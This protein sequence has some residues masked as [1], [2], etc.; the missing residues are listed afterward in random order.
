MNLF[1]RGFDAV[2]EEEK[3]R[4]EYQKN[5]AGIYRLYVKEGD[6]PIVFL[7]EEPV[8]FYEHNVKN[9]RNGKTYFDSVMCTGDKCPLCDTGDRPSFKSA[10]LVLDLRP[11]E[12]E[13]NGKKKT[14][15][16]Q[17]KLYVVGTKTAGI[18]QRKSQ[19]YGL[20]G[21]KYYLERIGKDTNTTYNLEKDG[22][23]KIS[24]E[25]IEE[26]LSKEYKEM[27]DGSED[28]LMDIIEAEI[29]KTASKGKEFTHDIDDEVE[30]DDDAI[31]GVDDE[32]ET[33][34]HKKA[35]SVFKNKKSNKFKLKK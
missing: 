31:L 13:D 16:R 22:R 11:Y 23:Y 33:P 7:T 34:K 20:A 26:L 14:I 1:K 29:S 10:W 32:D 18:I 17:L 5:K 15:E 19:R 12:Y 6:A 2:K 8:N 35:K 21:I 30:D 4:E 3:R 24:E 25:E 9:T 27:Y 28:S